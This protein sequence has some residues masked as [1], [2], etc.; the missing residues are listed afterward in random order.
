MCGASSLFRSS[1]WSWGLNLGR[2]ASAAKHFSPSVSLS[3]LELFCDAVT[4]HEFGSFFFSY[5]ILALKAT[6][7]R[8]NNLVC[9]NCKQI[10]DC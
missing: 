6:P 1:C 2:Y 7:M 8:V 5:N 10:Q 3:D 4:Y 9:D